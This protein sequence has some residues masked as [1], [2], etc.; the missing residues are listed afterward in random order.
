MIHVEW[1][2]GIAC[3]VSLGPSGDGS[4]YVVAVD[5]G[6]HRELGV[7]A[8]HES[9]EL[10]CEPVHMSMELPNGQYCSFKY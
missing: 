8:A 1:E 6:A 7:L 3:P 10:G 2:V 4:E 9:I 5:V